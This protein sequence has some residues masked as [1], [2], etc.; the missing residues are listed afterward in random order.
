MGMYRAVLARTG[1]KELATKAMTEMRVAEARH[2]IG[3]RK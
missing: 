1:N 2:R 3:K